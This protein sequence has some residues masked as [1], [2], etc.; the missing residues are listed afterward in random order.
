LQRVDQS[1]PVYYQ[2]EQ[3]LD[4][5]G[6]T[7]GVFTRQ[8]GVSGGPWG[9]LNVGGTVGDEPANVQR[10]ARLIYETLEVDA[11]RVCT[12]WQVHSADT[13]IASGPTPGRRWLARADGLVTDRPGVSLT[14]RFADCVPILFYDASHQALGI[15]HAGWRG[16]VSQVAASTLRTMQTAYG[17]DPAQVQAGIGPSI[18]PD[19]YQVGPEV[20]AAIEKAFGDAEG[21]IRYAQ[22]GS[23][24]L[25][26][27]EA[28]RL[29]LERAGVRRIEVAGLCT[30]SNTA[31]FYSHRAERGKTGRFCALI[32]L[33]D[34]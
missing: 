32:A 1:G 3:W 15:A 8:G 17:T 28:N 10:N 21:L 18:G 31:E 34:V 19:Q 26:L 14:M 13:V 29:T 7:H 20:V 11:T 23:A 6:L 9:T 22:D 16:T 2:F 4:A 5:P 33:K 24:Y 30:A 12:V 25:N 27:W